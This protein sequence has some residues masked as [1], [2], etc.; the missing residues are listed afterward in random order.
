MGIT[1][2]TKD[3]TWVLS[4]RCDECLTDVRELNIYECADLMRST[5]CG[6]R[7]RLR[8]PNLTRRSDPDTWSP[9]E[10]AAHVRDALAVFEE[11]IR[12][13]LTQDNPVLPDWDQDT[14]AIEGNYNDSNPVTVAMQ[15]DSAITS[16]GGLLDGLDSAV[17]GRKGQRSDGSPFTVQ[18]LSR[19]FAHD[20]AHHLHDVTKPLL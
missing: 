3:W 4:Q 15:L 19:Y 16:A 6:W 7:D 13:M 8:E 17:Y 1:P 11:R 20:V 5:L 2:E 18:T 14:A 9:L 10:Y 12:L